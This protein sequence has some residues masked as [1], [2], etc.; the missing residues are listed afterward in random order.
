M[1]PKCEYNYEFRKRLNQVHRIRLNPPRNQQQSQEIQITDQ[2]QIRISEDAS[3][4]LFRVAQDLQD[5]FAVSLGIPLLLKRSD[6]PGGSAAQPAIVIGTKAEHPVAGQSLVTPRSFR[7]IAQENEVLLC[8]ADERGA[9]QG[10]YHLEDLLNLRQAPFLTPQEIIRAPIFSPRMVH[11]GWGI[12]QFP[13]QHLNAIA[14]AGLDAILIFVKDVN[15]TTTGFLDFNNAIE[16]AEAFGL[17][18]YFYSYIK[19][20]RHPEDADAAEFYEGTYGRLIR[21]CPKVKGVIFVGESCEFPSKDERSK[22]RLRLDPVPPG[23]ENDPRPFPGWWPCRDY[24]QWL[25]LVKGI[26]RKYNPALD[27]VFWTYNWGWAPTE[28]RLA[29][30]RNLPQDISLQVTFEMFENIEKGGIPT[31]CVDYTASFAGPGHYFRTEAETAR[32]KNIP[33]YAMANTGGLS[34]DI[35]VIPYQPIPFQWKERWDALLAAQRDWGLTGLMES[36]HYGWWPSFISELSKEAY[37]TNGRPF[38]EH[39]QM[40]A[41]RLFG[42]QGADQAIAG[43]QLWSSAA[44]DYVPTNE[45]QYGP[46]RIGPTYPLLFL[47][48][49]H[50]IPDAPYAHFGAHIVNT[51]YYPHNLAIVPGEIALL[52]NMAKKM[53]AGTVLLQEALLHS[54][55][56]SQDEAVCIARLGEFIGYCVQTTINVKRW[57]LC[58]QVLRDAQARQ[59]E[60]LSALAQMLSISQSEK[61]NVEAALP[62]VAQDSRLGWEP[63][64]EY[65]TDPEHLRW[66]LQLLQVTS[67]K[68]IPEF[69]QQLLQGE[70]GQ[71]RAPSGSQ[72]EAAP[73]WD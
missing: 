45:D 5:Y 68:S 30:I 71:Q 20:R 2:W 69:Q 6:S 28:D 60:K 31:R 15:I 37:W 35:G 18:V 58:N 49:D 48:E 26:M 53:R 47:E 52:Q 57:Y 43:W 41:E 72:P 51:P 34:W 70:E 29:L 46:F 73:P 23:Q 44:R 24:P 21:S 8:G 16:R 38:A 36:H 40:L 27:V 3:E 12:D 54:P 10:C 32:S 42:Q 14:H 39:L 11:S 61:E 25:Q 4:Y 66:K 50:K 1:T 22:G 13:D 67:L 19:S 64:M 56:V 65:M 17:D 7:L 59:A 55:P 9:A 63:S 33:L 62:L